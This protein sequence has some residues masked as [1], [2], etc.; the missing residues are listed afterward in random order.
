MGKTAQMADKKKVLLIGLDP[1]V[2]D[3]SRWPGLTAEMVDGALRAGEKELV[4]SGYDP[5]L[6]YLDDRETADTTLGRLLDETPFDCILIG[7]GIRNDPEEFPLFEI[8]VNTVL[9]H[10][11]NARICFN[12]GP[13]DLADAVRRWV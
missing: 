5:N 8:M 10:A 12:T 6:C 13:T 4:E 3:F 7:S 9:R 2:I 1:A 11:P